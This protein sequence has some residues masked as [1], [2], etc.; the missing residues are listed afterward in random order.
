[1]YADCS[2]Q[3]SSN[4]FLLFQTQRCRPAYAKTVVMPI[5]AVLLELS[6]LAFKEDSGSNA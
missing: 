4:W 3:F 2:C 6:A 1:M 5:T